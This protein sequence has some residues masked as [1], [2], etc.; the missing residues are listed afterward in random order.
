MPTVRS[1]ILIRCT[2]EEAELNQPPAKLLVSNKRLWKE[3]PLR[4]CSTQ[5]CFVV[6]GGRGTRW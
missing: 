2:A 4:L 6:L 5:S 1:A 3:A